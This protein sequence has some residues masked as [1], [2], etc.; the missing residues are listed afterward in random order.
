MLL[1]CFLNTFVFYYFEELDFQICSVSRVCVCVCML[2]GISLK[3]ALILFY[4]RWLEKS[5]ELMAFRF[6]F[7]CAFC[8]LLALLFEYIL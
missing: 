1:I 3:T 7:F 2:N 8:N 6:F 4:K 5:Y